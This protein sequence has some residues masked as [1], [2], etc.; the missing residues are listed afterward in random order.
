MSNRASIQALRVVSALEGFSWLFL[1]AAMIYRATTGNHEPVSICGRVHGGLFC[2]FGVA[3][4][5]AWLKN[6]WSYEF[7]LLIGMTSLVPTG[8]IFADHLLRKR[9]QDPS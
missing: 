5:I 2:V 3:L 4:L 8:F 6:R 1:I 9:L 7:G